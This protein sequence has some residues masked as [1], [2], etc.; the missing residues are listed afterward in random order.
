MVALTDYHRAL[1]GTLITP[2]DAVVPAEAELHRSRDAKGAMEREGGVCVCVRGRFLVLRLWVSRE[3]RQARE[4]FCLVSCSLWRISAGCVVISS[5]EHRDTDIL[6]GMMTGGP[7]S[8]SFARE[9][10]F[11]LCNSAGEISWVVMQ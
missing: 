10:D 4:T 3:G 5:S 8:A 1:F 9:C 11:L 6:S 2:T 7:F